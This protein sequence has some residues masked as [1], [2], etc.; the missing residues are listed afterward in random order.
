[1]ADVQD[2]SQ[3]CVGDCPG[4]D[5]RQGGSSLDAVLIADEDYRGNVYLGDTRTKIGDHAGIRPDALRIRRL[6]VFPE[7]RTGLN[8]VPQQQDRYKKHG[9]QQNSFE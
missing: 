3:L 2:D 9:H 7:V 6:T 5:V 1:M 8:P 4:K